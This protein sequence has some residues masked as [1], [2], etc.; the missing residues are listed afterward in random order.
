MKRHIIALT[1][2]ILITSFSAGVLTGCKPK[3]TTPSETENTTAEETTTVEE[4]TTSEET[5]VSEETTSSEETTT[6]ET[7][8]APTS[9][10]LGKV[11]VSNQYTHKKSKIPKITIEGVSTT[12]INKEILKKF[13]SDAN[14]KDVIVKYSYYIGKSFVSIVIVPSWTGEVTGG[15]AP[16]PVYVYNISRTT[17]KN[18]TRKQ[19]L[20]TLKI[21]DKKFNSKVKKGIKK[22][23]KD[24]F[25]KDFLKY[26]KSDYNRSIKKKYLK[27]AI[28]YYNTKGKLCFYIHDIDVPIG[29]GAM[30]MTGTL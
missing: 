26:Y 16:D 6:S 13:K 8:A 17:G 19:L 24:T 7:T 9:K 12:A 28:P 27:R 25:G 18:M 2:M 1:C 3:E 10:P 20:K 29:I 5:I 11:T 30:D 23:Y 4:T 15:D 14:D 22:F 21:S